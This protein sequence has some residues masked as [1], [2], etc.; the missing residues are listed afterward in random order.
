MKVSE[1]HNKMKAEF[2]SCRAAQNTKQ[3]WKS[4]QITNERPHGM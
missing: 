2:I 1:K 3:E 4:E